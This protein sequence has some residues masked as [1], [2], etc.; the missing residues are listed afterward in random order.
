MSVLAVGLIAG[1]CYDYTEPGPMDE[2]TRPDLE[3]GCDRTEWMREQ[4]IPALHNLVR[5]YL[6]AKSDA[7]RDMRRK[8]ACLLVIT[9]NKLPTDL[10][11][12]RMICADHQLWR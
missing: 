1:G 4:K 10:Q 2:A 11:E 8:L 5:Q 9:E 3:S 6:E 12:F 7:Y